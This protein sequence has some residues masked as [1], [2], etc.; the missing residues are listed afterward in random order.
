[1]RNTA[2]PHFYSV[3]AILKV[4]GSD[5]NFA[6]IYYLKLCLDNEDSIA[7]ASLE[8]EEPPPT[9]EKKESHLNGRNRMQWKSCDIRIPSSPYTVAKS[10]WF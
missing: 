2:I 3:R 7:Q 8:D 10:T 5:Y 6:Y 4:R 9:T 1:M